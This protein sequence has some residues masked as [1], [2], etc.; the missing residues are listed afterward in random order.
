MN[1]TLQTDMD[2]IFL[3]SGFE[4]DIV[5]TPSGGAAKTISAIVDR[6][7]SEVFS[8][9]LQA[10]L[11]LQSYRVSIQ[12]SKTDVSVVTKQ[13]DIVTLSHHGRISDTLHVVGILYEDTASY[14]LGLA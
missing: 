1:L 2:N 10:R 4:E 3:G 14:T 9:K 13:E 6:A 8:P 5:Y 7:S 11:S 12:V